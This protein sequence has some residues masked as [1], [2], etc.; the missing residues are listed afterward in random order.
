VDSPCFGAASRD[1]QHP[2]HD[3]SLDHMVKPQPRNAPLVPNAPCQP[4]ERDGPSS[5][6]GGIGVC[7]FGT[8]AAQAVRTFALL[9]DSHAMTWRAPLEVV[10]Q[11]KHWRGLS[12]TRGRC[13]LSTARV[14][15]SLAERTGCVRWN[16]RVTAWL[17]RH[18][19]IDLVFVAGRSTTPVIAA[20]HQTA[21]ATKIEG[22]RAAWA[23]L[24][25]TVRHIIVI[26]DNPQIQLGTFDCIHR[27][28]AAQ[29]RPGTSCALR[30]PVVLTRDPAIAAVKRSQSER[31][32][33]IDLTSFMCSDALCYPVVGGALVNKDRTHLATG[34]A[35]T[36]GPFL[37][38]Q[39]DRLARRWRPRLLSLDPPLGWAFVRW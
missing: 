25:D 8:P 7:A 4:I 10:A 2:C 34:F 27:A 30:R 24:P 1:A 33:R 28:I 13:A 19:E 39:T 31:V 23:A 38:Q 5:F 6:A 21:F 14:A 17:A 3:P 15:V 36:L 16:K 11:S 37:L 22:Y 32:Q 12:I 35:T 26:R 20:A 9:G 18:P 29:Q